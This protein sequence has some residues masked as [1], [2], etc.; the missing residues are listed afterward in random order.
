MSNSSVVRTAA[1]GRLQTAQHLD[2]QCPIMP[3][4]TLNEKLGIAADVLPAD[5]DRS[6]VNMVV[7]GYGGHG[8]TTGANN[9]VKWEKFRH[10]PRHAAMFAQIP[11]VM[12]KV[13]EDLT[14]SQRMKYR[15]RRIERHS[16][17]DYVCYY[18]RILD[19]TNI[20]IQTELRQVRDGVTTTTPFD[21]ALEDLNPIPTSLSVGEVVQTNGDYIATTAKVP[22]VMSEEDVTEFMNV[23]EIMHHDPGYAVIS[24]FATVSS[25]DRV[26]SMTINGQAQSY[27]EAI[28]AQIT[29]FFQSGFVVEH[30]TSG[31]TINLNVGNVEPLLSTS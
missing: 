13:S 3:N 4:S 29:S 19:K 14:I 9:R 2:I 21:Y 25:I 31:F 26:V 24:E 12:R 1:A 28:Q 6:S 20:L 18:G 17:Q 30:L 15:L 10:M 16:G 11:F 27:T 22:F 5:T 23:I 7:I 8:F